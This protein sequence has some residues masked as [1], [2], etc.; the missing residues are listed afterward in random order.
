MNE[1]REHTAGLVANLRSGKWREQ[2]LTAQRKNTKQAEVSLVAE[3]RLQFSL[4]Q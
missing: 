3:N 2:E 1:V 4:V